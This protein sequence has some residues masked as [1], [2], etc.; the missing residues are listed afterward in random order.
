MI[1]CQTLINTS[2][3]HNSKLIAEYWVECRGL[4][5]SLHHIFKGSYCFSLFPFIP[6]TTN[7]IHCIFG[8]FSNHTKYLTDFPSSRQPVVSVY[9]STVWKSTDKGNSSQWTFGQ[10]LFLPNL[11]HSCVT[12]CTVCFNIPSVVQVS[13][14]IKSRLLDVYSVRI[15]DA[16]SHDPFLSSH[17][18]FFSSHLSGS[19]VRDSLNSWTWTWSLFADSSPCNY[20]KFSQI[21]K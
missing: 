15:L 18:R 10:L 16:A 3:Y 1:Y 20:N 9:F 4:L 12:Q 19:V 17:V 13:K 8:P 11:V 5:L 2:W 6:L 14:R 21:H 7:C